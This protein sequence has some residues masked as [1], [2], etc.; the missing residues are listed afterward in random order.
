MKKKV[1]AIIPARMES[2]RFPGKPLISMSGL[3]MVEHVRRR[4]CLSKVIDEV[5]VATCN[6]EIFDAVAGFGG[7]AVMTADT[8][9]RCTD[10]VEEAI[11]DKSADIVVN[12]QGD[13]PLLDPDMLDLLI[14][15]LLA[16]SSLK[17]ANIISVIHDKADLM[18]IN[19][20]KTVMNTK[21]NIMYYS[22]AP[23]PYLMKP[24]SPVLYRQTGLS[25]FTK[26]FLHTYSSLAPTPLEQAESVDFLRILEHDYPIMGV[27]VDRTTIGVDRPEDVAKVE[28]LL[29]E[30][31]RQKQLH[32]E[33]L[34]V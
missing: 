17:C 12:V 2:S 15:P 33:C 8:H 5:Y 11:R 7:K 30:D 13:E 21:G 1:T 4:T 19:I 23:I 16:N 34:K 18:D 6:R 24:T 31:P 26:D 29:R 3:P 32:E 20:V 9:V 10:R 25:A 14:E 27:V 28:A 22:R